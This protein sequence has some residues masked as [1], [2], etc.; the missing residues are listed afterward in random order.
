MAKYTNTA[1]TTVREVEEIGRVK[2]L[3]GIL[4]LSDE[5]AYKHSIEVAKIVEEFVIIA[6]GDGV[7]SWTDAEVSSVL[8]GALLHDVGKAFLPFGLQH[9]KNNISTLEKEVI[10]MHPMLGAVAIENCEFDDIIK[11]IVLMH[12]A[13]ADGTGYPLLEGR[14]LNEKNVPDYVWAVSYADRFDAIINR[15]S[16]RVAKPLSEA[17]QDLASEVTSGRLPYAFMGAYKCIARRRD[18]FD[19]KSYT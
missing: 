2:S 3:L 16:Y 7:V 5:E 6:R 10:N 4:K 17:W 12:H 14:Q 18:I 11:N 9:S 15:R 19:G 8:I 1:P 13:N